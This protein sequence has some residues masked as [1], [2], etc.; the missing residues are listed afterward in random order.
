MKKLAAV[1]LIAFGISQAWAQEHTESGR[2]EHPSGL[3]YKPLSR[4]PDKDKARTNPLEGDPD[5]I[6]AGQKLFTQHCAEC[7]GENLGGTSRGINLMDE[8]V[9]EASPGALFWILT[10]GV[11]RRGMPVWS[12]L[13]EPQRWQLVAFLKSVVGE[14]KRLRSQ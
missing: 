8:E 4:V 6:A 5:A 11:V 10:N 2:R 1:A 13:P 12:K 7:H 3:D 14:P 9:Q